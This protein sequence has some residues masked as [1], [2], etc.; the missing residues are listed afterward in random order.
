MESIKIRRKIDSQDLH[1]EELEPLIGQEAEII[2]IPIHKK[3]RFSH[4]EIMKLAGSVTTGEDPDIFK[5]RIRD[6]WNSRI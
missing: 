1:I 6:E 3:S 2:I 4:K 5:N